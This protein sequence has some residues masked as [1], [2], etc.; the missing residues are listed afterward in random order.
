MAMRWVLIL[1]AIVVLVMMILLAC[2][3]EWDG[4]DAVWAVLSIG[5]ISELTLLILLACHPE[6]GRAAKFIVRKLRRC[7]RTLLVAVFT[8][9]ACNANSGEQALARID[10]TVRDAVHGEFETLTVKLDDHSA[11]ITAA[12]QQAVVAVSKVDNSTS[13]RVVNRVL[14]IG[15]VLALIMLVATYPVGKVL[16]LVGRRMR[17]QASDLGLRDELSRGSLPEARSLKSEV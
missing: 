11:R 8:P 1:G 17:L 9:L 2:R 7:P 12:T 3:P 15:A 13:D 10:A 5:M 14:S 16:W 4:D 6:L